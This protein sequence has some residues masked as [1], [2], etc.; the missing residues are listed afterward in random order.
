M[1]KL[2]PGRIS[3][4]CSPM[5]LDWTRACYKQNL[6]SANT[7]AFHI[8]HFTFQREK[9]PVSFPHDNRWVSTRYHQIIKDAANSAGA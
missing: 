4:M 7:R 6:S 1:N 5:Y 3:A 9:C 8:S 2:Q